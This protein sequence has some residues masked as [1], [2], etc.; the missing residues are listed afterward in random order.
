MAAGLHMQSNVQP[1][2]TR[3]EL[4][5]Q[6]CHCS[7]NSQALLVHFGKS[8]I[9]LPSAFPSFPCRS[10][11]EH[12]QTACASFIQVLSLLLSP[13]QSL[14]FILCSPSFS[15]SHSLHIPA[16]C[17]IPTRCSPVPQPIPFI[18]TARQS[19]LQPRDPP[20]CAA[21]KPRWASVITLSTTLCLQTLRN[22]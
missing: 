13:M 14:T 7:C 4:V 10:T 20:S 21:C 2:S 3:G 16:C 17:R 1:V 9:P 11:C 8:L 5:F 6:F 22:M 15:M 12:Y 19:V 18:Q